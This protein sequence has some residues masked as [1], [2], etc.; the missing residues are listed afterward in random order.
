MEV[1]YFVF[2]F[3]FLSFTRNPFFLLHKKNTLLPLILY[4]I[5]G[6]QHLII[7]ALKKKNLIIKYQVISHNLK[8][9]KNPC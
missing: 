6:I 3:A 4:A 2:L 9:K 8:K 5:M 1:N 7:K